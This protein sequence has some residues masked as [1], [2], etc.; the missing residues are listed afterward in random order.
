MKKTIALFTILSTVIF[1]CCKNETATKEAV[2]L[3]EPT[4]IEELGELLFFDPILSRDSSISCASCHKPEFAFADNVPLSFGVDSLKGTRNTPSAM[5]LASRSFFFHDGRSESL[6]DQ[7]K[8]PMQ[9]PVEM[10][11]PLSTII[12]RLKRHQQY[13]TFFQKQFGQLP[14]IENLTKALSDY[15]R[16]LETADT[17][18]DDYQ[19]KYDTTQFSESAK[20]GRLIFNQKGK[21]FDCH[22]GP[23]FTGDQFRNIGLFNGKELNDSGRYVVT[24][25]TTDLGKF[26]TP[27]L[28]NALVTAPYMHN[29]MFS[30][31]KEVIDYYNEPGKVVPNSINRDTL[32]SKP[33]GL[34][35]QEKADLEA[36][37]ISLTDRRFVKK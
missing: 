37:L 36:F 28:R 18:F 22:F 33:L 16:S 6:E 3:K 31:L 12:E 8:G 35:P 30:T 21:C 4:S 13:K 19:S 9:N 7:A 29:G 15:E 32:L 5:N 34:T 23:D 2:L 20:R 25:K 26:K 11:M 10:N 1:F 24:K 27:G 17:P 14:T